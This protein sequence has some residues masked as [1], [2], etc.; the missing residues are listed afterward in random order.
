MLYVSKYDEKSKLYSVTDTDDGVTDT[1]SRTELL[2]A[3]K[4]L[5]KAG[6]RFE[7]VSGDKIYVSPTPP[8][9]GTR[10]AASKVNARGDALPKRN[11]Q[12]RNKK[13]KAKP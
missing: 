6:V 2:N 5:A 9:R 1:M 8:K 11:Y 3:A 10:V 13:S 12:V 7:G 4:L